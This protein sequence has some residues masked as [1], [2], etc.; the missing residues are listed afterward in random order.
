MG[1]Q[2]TYT[3]NLANNGRWDDLTH[4]YVRYCQ[5]FQVYNEYP[6]TIH[7]SHDGDVREM[8]RPSQAYLAKDIIINWIQSSE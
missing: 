5:T 1:K 7:Y 4:M 3:L 2:G 6:G 8:G